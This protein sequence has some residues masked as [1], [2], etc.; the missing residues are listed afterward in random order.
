MMRFGSAI[1]NL[2]IAYRDQAGIIPLVA[3]EVI[4]GEGV[5]KLLAIG[6]YENFYHDLK[7]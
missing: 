7:R 1:S 2:T 3:Y 4:E 5:I 6:E